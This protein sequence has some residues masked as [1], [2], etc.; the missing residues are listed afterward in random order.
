MGA[1]AERGYDAVHIDDYP[2]LAADVARASD[3][4]DSSDSHT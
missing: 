1:L 4:I 3:S 2:H